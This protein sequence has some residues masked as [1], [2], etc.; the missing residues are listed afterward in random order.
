MN[1]TNTYKSKISI[2]FAIHTIIRPI[3]HDL[4]SDDLFK[5]CLH[6]LTQ[7]T[8]EAFNSVI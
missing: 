4:S 7:N 3:F 1:G 6:G 2:P 8:N 5:K